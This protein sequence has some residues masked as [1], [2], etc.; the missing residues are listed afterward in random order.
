MSAY[1]VAAVSTAL[2]IKVCEDCLSV[3]SLSSHAHMTVIS[4]ILFAGSPCTCNGQPKHN[5]LETSSYLC[6]TCS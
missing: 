6:S 3:T 5:A 4:Y 1:T 2:W